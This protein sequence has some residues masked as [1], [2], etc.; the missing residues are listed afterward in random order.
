MNTI[1]DFEPEKGLALMNIAMAKGKARI[2]RGVY[3]HDSK[4]LIEHQKALPNGDTGKNIDFTT[5]PFWIVV[6]GTAKGN[7]ISPC[8][9]P[10]EVIELADKDVM[11]SIT[12][13]PMEVSHID[14]NKSNNANDNL[15]TQTRPRRMAGQTIITAITREGKIMKSNDIIKIYGGEAMLAVQEWGVKNE[16]KLFGVTV[17]EWSELPEKDVMRLMAKAYFIDPVYKNMMILHF[18]IKEKGR[19]VTVYRAKS[20]HFGKGIK[21]PIKFTRTKEFENRDITPIYPLYQVLVDR[22]I[23]LPFKSQMKIKEYAALPFEDKGD[24][25]P[26]EI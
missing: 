20:R 24:M 23:I 1:T 18:D 11:E 22:K 4:D 25:K 26:T 9:T 19:K 15:Q 16:L 8:H 7:T 6:A 2:G 17:A 5:A 14:G 3:L 12:F 10:Q 21:W 13:L